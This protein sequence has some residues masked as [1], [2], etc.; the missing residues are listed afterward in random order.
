LA[1]S[2]ALKTEAIYSS[3]TASHSRAYIITDIRTS[4]AN[5]SNNFPLKMQWAS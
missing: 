4:D 3:K 1:C 2:S 5:N